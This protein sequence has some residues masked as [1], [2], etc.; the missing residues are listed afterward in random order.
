MNSPRF[1]G[2]WLLLR[3]GPELLLYQ[4]NTVL[5]GNK[6]VNIIFGDIPHKVT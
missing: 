1:P 5:P 6:I 2:G 3:I 4:V